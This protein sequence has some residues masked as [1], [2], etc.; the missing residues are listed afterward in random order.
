LDFRVSGFRVQG[1]GVEVLRLKSCVIGLRHRLIK[2]P[3]SRV[4][5]LGFRAWGL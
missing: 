5:G 3:G 2:G 4:Q 1:S